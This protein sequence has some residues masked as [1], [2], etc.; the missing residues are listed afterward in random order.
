MDKKLPIIKAVEQ[1]KPTKAEKA[2]EYIKPP[3][4]EA[5]SLTMTEG[6]KKVI[7]SIREK[8]KGN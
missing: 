1:L 3:A 4:V 5:D 6:G 7:K 8:M 2:V